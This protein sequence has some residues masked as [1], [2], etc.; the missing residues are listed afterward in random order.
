MVEDERRY[1]WT[2]PTTSVAHDVV[3]CAMDFDYREDRRWY[4]RLGQY[5]THRHDYDED[6]MGIL[7]EAKP[8]IRSN[9]DQ[10]EDQDRFPME[11]F[12]DNALH[13]MRRGFRKAERRF[14]NRFVGIDTFR[15]VRD[16]IRPHAKHLDFPGQEF[17]LSYGDGRARCVEIFAEEEL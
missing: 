15:A 2:A 9:F 3:T 6:F 12:I 8:M 14:G 4:P 16:A 5:R 13:L 1:G 11:A 17:R 10:D 7:E